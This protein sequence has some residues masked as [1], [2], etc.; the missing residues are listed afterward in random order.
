MDTKKP[1]PKP[2]RSEVLLFLVSVVLGA[3]LSF[4][5]PT[6]IIA[7]DWTPDFTDKLLS[8][9]PFYFA[10]CLAAAVGIVAGGLKWFPR[11]IA[12]ATVAAT[13]LTLSG[14]L[15]PLKIFRDEEA[16]QARILEADRLADSILSMAPLS[17][18]SLPDAA[19]AEIRKIAV[20]MFGEEVLGP[21]YMKPA[22]R[23]E[24]TQ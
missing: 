14:T 22:P 17:P 9:L 12:L 15:L 24:V 21:D 5:D 2:T 4:V 3:A 8:I 18:E 7:Q 13:I 10:G 19:R 16:R 20:S 23:T 6:E 1:R 11:H